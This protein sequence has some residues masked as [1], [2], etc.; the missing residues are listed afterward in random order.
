VN[1]L[2][3]DRLREDAAGWTVRASPA[4]ITVVIVMG[5]LASAA[6]WFSGIHIA[7]RIGLILLILA[8]TMVTLK[9]LYSPRYRRLAVHESGLVVT[10]ADGRSLQLTLIGRAF[11]S[12]IYI[13]LAGRCAG[14]RGVRTLGLFRGQLE[15]QA[16]R[17]L[18]AWLRNQGGG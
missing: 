3:T 12:P 17:Q 13:G 10:R 15:D 4:L 5:T 6:A 7:M 9:S 16:Y 14:R 1:T 18:A 8:Y 11:V 2:P